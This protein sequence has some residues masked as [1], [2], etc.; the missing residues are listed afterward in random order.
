M[1][2]FCLYILGLTVL[3]GCGRVNKPAEFIVGFSQCITS[4]QWRQSMQRDMERELQFYPEI[5][6]EIRD[7]NGSNDLQINQ[8]K[9][10]VGLKIDLLIVSP[11]EAEPITPAV[12]EAY[13]KGIPVI[14]IDRKT[15]SNQYTAYIGANNFKLGEIAG[16]YIETILPPNSRI[17]EIWG[18]RGSTPAI[19]RHQG[20]NGQLGDKHEIIPVYSDWTKNYAKEEFRKLI[21]T[22]QNINLVYAHNDVM[23]L[24]A[25]EVCRELGIADRISFVGIDGLPGPTGGMQMVTDGVL[26]A[27]LLY[28]TGGEEA[29]RLAASILRGQSFNKENELQTTLINQR[30]VRILKLQSDKISNQQVNIQRQQKRYNEQLEL[31]DD[32]RSLIY[33]LSASL[34]VTILLTAYI[35]YSLKEKQE[36][37]KKL[38]IRNDE[39]VSQRNEILTISNEAEEANAA[40]LKFFTNISH[41][42]RT[43]LT[44]ILGPVEEL[45]AQSQDLSFRLKT[46]LQL[47]QKN[48]YRMLRLINQL[49]EFRKIE[50]GKMEVK[51]SENDLVKFVKD[52][53]D[54]FNR[55]SKENQIN[56]SIESEFDSFDLWF[57]VNMLDKVIF[58][59]LSNAFKFTPEDGFIKIQIKLSL[60]HI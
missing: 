16:E 54:S 57:D 59:L 24:G 52:I 55:L 43:P 37:N 23:A 31:Y 29:I 22:D 47:I 9:E 13:E 46:D 60:I 56:F 10:L 32:Q 4:D 41:E 7:A 18:L 30:N 28:P 36:I 51:A 25:Y 17:V 27:T 44:L 53:K 49:M 48:A 33:G 5:F 38:A 58:N 35:L 11:N 3:Y 40:K 39:V 42:F 12:E 2:K 45:L 26:D 14:I 15:S 6:L 8:I 34:I 19:D 50:N 1:K 21:T 20:L